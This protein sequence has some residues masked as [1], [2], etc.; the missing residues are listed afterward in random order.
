MWKGLCLGTAA[1]LVNASASIAQQHPAQAV[2][3]AEQTQFDPLATWYFAR[4]DVTGLARCSA[5]LTTWSLDYF[6]FDVAGLDPT[7]SNKRTWLQ[8]L[9][10]QMDKSSCFK[11][12]WGQKGAIGLSVYVNGGMAPGQWTGFA[13][14]TAR[15]G[16]KREIAGQLA[17]ARF[18]LMVAGGE[19][20][21]MIEDNQPKDRYPKSRLLQLRDNIEALQAGLVRTAVIQS[22]QIAFKTLMLSP[23]ADGVDWHASGIAPVSVEGE[24]YADALVP[25]ALRGIT[26]N[27]ATAD[28][29]FPCA[30][31]PR[32]LIVAKPLAIQMRQS[33]VTIAPQLLQSIAAQHPCFNRSS[34]TSFLQL[35]M[36]EI[37]GSQVPV[38]HSRA[39]QITSEPKALIPGEALLRHARAR[40]EKLVALKGKLLSAFGDYDPMS[41]EAIAAFALIEDLA[42][43]YQHACK[44]GDGYQCELAQSVLP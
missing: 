32:T 37:A 20:R 26:Y 23:A 39:G 4:K 21:Q 31:K 41:E 18:D 44:D 25:F 15:E 16:Q 27:M 28:G 12:L 7:Y 36:T 13:K 43:E 38:W 19:I 33:V 35:E 42:R 8:A 10:K 3:A 34:D 11:R 22:E 9:H 6:E 40:V 14:V 29:Y 5:P 1:L 24:A 30:F 17:G 2:A